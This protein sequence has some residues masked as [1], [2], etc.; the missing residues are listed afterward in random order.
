MRPA[1][2]LEA[3]TPSRGSNSERRFK[4]S[5]LDKHMTYLNC[6]APTGASPLTEQ[7][8]YTHPNRKLVHGV[9]I[10][11]YPAPI[12]VD[13]KHIRSY[14]VWQG[15]LQRCYSAS[16]QK[17]Y[18]TYTGCSVAEEW[19]RFSTFE[20][21]FSSNY[22]EGCDLDKDILFPGNKLYSAETCVFV[23]HKLNA[24]LTDGKAARGAH[25]IG[26]SFHKGAQKY[27]ALIRT[28]AGQI[29]LGSFSTALEA[30]QMWQL[31]KADIIANFPTADL[32]IRAALDK[33][34]AQLRD[35]YANNRITTKL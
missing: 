12:K 21:W 16:L 29:H 7:K 22:I 18:P 6:T 24:M 26:V 34:A 23:P 28:G 30:H 35:D 2:R 9:G 19:L 4:S 5:F 27:R 13:Y 20:R 1:F 25:P 14:K 31:A 33:R 15:M 11:D 3:Q 8:P 32:R 10:N 17:G